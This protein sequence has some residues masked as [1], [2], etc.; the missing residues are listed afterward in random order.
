MNARFRMSIVALCIAGVFAG[1]GSVTQGIAFQP[2]AGWTGTPAMFGRF[3]IWMKSGQ[4]KDSNQIL[5]LIKGDPRHMHG[6]LTNL[7]P[8]YSS[9]LKVVKSGTT[10]LCG[11]TQQAQELVGEGTDKNG[12]R[13]AVEMTSDVIGADRYIAMY[14]HPLGVRPDPAAE[15]AIH[16]LCPTK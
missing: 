6:D 16:S 5:M 4:S 10:R 15:S 8:Q 1:C 3:Q 7:P 11:G 14:I 9:N 12:K 2:P 13:S